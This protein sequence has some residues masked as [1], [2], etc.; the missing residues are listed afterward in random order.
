[1]NKY[2]ITQVS[3]DAE[4]LFL[5]D[6]A[7]TSGLENL[8]LQSPDSDSIDLWCDI[9]M[10]YVI[11][12]IIII[13]II[14]FVYYSCSQNATTEPTCVTQDSTDTIERKPSI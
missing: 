10:Y 9:I 6:S 1:M 12:I 11:I 13:I 8:G 3:R 14:M 7:R 4:S 2:F 5:W